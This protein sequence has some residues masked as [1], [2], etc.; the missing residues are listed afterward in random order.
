VPH[1]VIASVHSRKWL[2]ITK[3]DVSRVTGIPYSTLKDNHSRVI[4]HRVQGLVNYRVDGDYFTSLVTAIT[5]VPAG[6]YP[7]FKKKNR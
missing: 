4:Q 7:V 1:E 3:K 2:L 5:G 6:K